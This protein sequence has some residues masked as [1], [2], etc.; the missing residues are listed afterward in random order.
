MKAG[1]TDVFVVDASAALAWCFKDERS[2]SSQALL[3]RCE[4]EVMHVPA[5]WFLECGNI[6]LNAE[7]HRRLT[8]QQIQDN[9]ALLNSLDPKVDDAAAV[10]TF[11]RIYDLARRHKLTVYDA[12]Y[13]ELAKRLAVPLATRDDDLKRAAREAGVELIDA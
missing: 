1:S 8:H 12:A 11:G 6:L 4:T 10:L 13:L 3:A 5:L 9:L 7:R 2:D